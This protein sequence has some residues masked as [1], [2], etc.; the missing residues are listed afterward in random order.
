MCACVRWGEGGVINFSA[1]LLF[2]IIGDTPSWKTFITEDRNVHL[3]KEMGKAKHLVY[4]TI[5]PSH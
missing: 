2:E 3:I 4:S 1:L 5:A